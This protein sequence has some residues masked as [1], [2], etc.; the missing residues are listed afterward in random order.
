MDTN[1][2]DI[3]HL[4]ADVLLPP[5]KRLLA[6]FKN[7]ASNASGASDQPIAASSTSSPSP[8][9]PSSA[10]S[11]SDVDAHLNN[12]L[13]SR[14]NNPN[15]SP[16]EIY[17][18]SR[19]A[20]IAAAK[21]AEAAQAAAE[22]KAAIAAKAIAA[23]KSALD[24]VATFYEDAGSKDK[25]LKKNKLKKH[26]P[27][28][29]LYKKHQPIENSR[30]DEDLAQRLHRAINSSPRI[31]KDSPISECKGHQQKRPKSLPTL[32]STKVPNGGIVLRG[33]PP[34]TCNGVRMAAEIDSDDLV[35][36]HVK[37]ANY[38]TSWQS[39]LDNGEAESKEKACKDTYSSGKKEGKSEAKEV[40]IEH[41]FL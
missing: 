6:G 5:R 10:T 17:E 8:P 36:E 25:Y 9:S 26:V 20:A 23:A 24:M 27:V 39:V 28:Q 32:D 40:A 38:E 22:E 19:A 21:A 4:D 29:V 14:F 31:S 33:S 1:V 16:E 2:C 30:I 35:K 13:S 7:R 41:L 34:S 3:N 15:L 18:A 11:S 12:L 37:V